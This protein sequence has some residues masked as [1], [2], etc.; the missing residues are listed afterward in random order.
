MSLIIVLRFL[1]QLELCVL[2]Q[3]T[4]AR[5]VPVEAKIDNRHFYFEGDIGCCTSGFARRVAADCIQER[6]GT[7][8]S[9]KWSLAAK[10]ALEDSTLSKPLQGF[11][12]EKAIIAELCWHGGEFLTSNPGRF[13]LSQQA[14]ML[15]D[16]SRIVSMTMFS[17]P[18]PFKFNQKGPGK[19]V[20]VP[21]AF[22]YT[23]VDVIVVLQED[24]FTKC[25]KPRVFVFPIQITIADEH[26]DSEDYFN[27]NCRKEWED[28]N[29]DY[30]IIWHFVWICKTKMRIVRQDKTTE[31]GFYHVEGR[32]HC[33]NKP[34]AG[35][36]RTH[37]DI[38]NFSSP[39]MDK[40]D[41]GVK[42]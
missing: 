24:V 29:S 35:C 36:S 27:K 10:N 6:R 22:N 13:N 5:Y 3:K 4:T 9:H 17:K 1:D 11:Y 20:L 2:G 7:L 19:L 25:H 42:K 32:T 28:Q 34:P 30:E 38:G 15:Q 39:L 21:T 16:A 8:D 12:T 26:K 33:E 23:A 41:D 18:Q 37:V 14:T 31:A 40:G